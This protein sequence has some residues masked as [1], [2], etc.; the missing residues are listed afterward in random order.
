ME[1]SCKKKKSSIQKTIS[2]LSIYYIQTSSIDVKDWNRV[3]NVPRIVSMCAL[4]SRNFQNVKLRL[5]FVFTATPI[6]RE[7]EFCQIQTVQF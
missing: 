7:I 2:F 1:F 3:S 4:W 5:D 6:L